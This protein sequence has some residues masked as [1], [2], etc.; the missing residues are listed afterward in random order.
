M[1]EPRLPH[2]L[3]PIAIECLKDTEGAIRLIGKIAVL[4]VFAFGV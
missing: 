4:V 3:S 2:L 1:F